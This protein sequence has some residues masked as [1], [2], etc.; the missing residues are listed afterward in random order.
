MG[1][2]LALTMPAFM[3]C[4]ICPSEFTEEEC[5]NFQR[6]NGCH[7]CDKRN[8]WHSKPDC[9]F[10]GRA[11]VHHRDAELG[12]SVPHMRETAITCM[13]D[14]EAMEGLLSPH[15]WHFYADVYFTVNDVEHLSMGT[16]SGYQCNCLID[17][18]RQQLQIDC[19]IRAVREHVQTRHPT[20]P[21]G[22]FLE[23]QHHWRDILSGF[24]AVAG[25]HIVPED[26]K[27]ICI[28]AMYI[29]NG[30]VEGD[31]ANIIYIARQDANHFVPLKRRQSP[32][33]AASASSSSAKVDFSMHDDAA[34]VSE[35][36][37]DDS[38]NESEV[39]LEDAKL[40]EISLNKDSQLEA[41]DV[42]NAQRAIAGMRSLATRSLA[43]AMQAA[44]SGNQRSESAENMEKSKAS[45]FLADEVMDDEPDSSSNA[46]E[47]ENND[48]DDASSAYDSDASDL[49]HLEVES[50]AT[51]ET[52]QDKDMRVAHILA[53][54]MRRH[55][56]VPALP[57]DDSGSCSFIAIDSGIKL[58]AAHCAFKHCCWIGTSKDS[59][60][61]HV[62][63]QHSAQ[64]SSAEKEVFGDS[65][66]YGSSKRLTLSLIHI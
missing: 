20:L 18:L 8:C 58:P 50:A 22:A 19:D 32:V 39:L 28:D 36:V 42:E 21:R 54:Q 6:Q 44:K 11:R 15:W 3:P 56:L 24:S 10:F 34:D 49:F 53:S 40:P 64:L 14:G 41:E 30:D 57:D 61:E 48:D 1:L 17:T 13:A 63:R 66:Y 35:V 12:D 9:S 7:A 43:S 5:V 4:R 25:R 55:P 51:W 65:I 37:C 26:Y 59:I 16:A 27:I 45:T 62:V 60:V 52:P 2:L 38:G 46:S 33:A 29:G 47:P 23:L 31:G